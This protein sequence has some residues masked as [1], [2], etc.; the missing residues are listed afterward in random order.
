M[1]GAS[2]WVQT[3]RTA[4]H[5]AI[6]DGLPG[7][8]WVAHTKP[9]QEKALARNFLSLSIFHY[10]PLGFRVTRS[11]KSGRLSES[12]IPVFPGYLF[13]NATETQRDQALQTNRIANLLSVVDQDQLLGELRQIQRVLASGQDYRTHKRLQV[14]QAVRILAGPLAD[15]EG[16]VRER[17]SRLR[18][19]LNVHMLGQSVSVEV[20][21]DA[22]ASI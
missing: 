2:Q 5:E 12:A 3:I 4:P 8:W 1:H 15:L 22:V 16:I 14:G 9:R 19:V 17:R 7:R 20:S 6:P 21:R 18:L 13:F 10:L 11:R